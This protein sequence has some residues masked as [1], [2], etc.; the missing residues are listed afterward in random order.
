MF[1]RKNTPWGEAM[2]LSN[3]I[4]AV[5]ALS[6]SGTAFA[7]TEWSNRDDRFTVN[8]P[9]EPTRQDMPYKTAKGTNLIA[10]VYTAQAPA[11][12]IQAGTYSV[13]VV[14]YSSAQDELA[15]AIDEAS[16]AIRAKGMAKYD[17][18]GAID[19]M[20]SQRLTI[21]T[22][23]KRRIFA[24]VVAEGGRL[25]V[26]QANTALN[27]PPPAQFQASIQILDDKGMRIRYRRLGSTERVN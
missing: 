5:L 16:V 7:Q 22:A 21:E 13:T 26:V 20:K 17:E 10:H 25:Y 23:D 4:P 9:A 6:L 11:S 14:D 15:T 19:Q 27:V 2:R 18:P 12:S 8:F 24:E 1:G 3:L